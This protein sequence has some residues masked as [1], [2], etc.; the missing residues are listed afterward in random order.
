LI[1][2]FG[3]RE[4][5]LDKFYGIGGLYLVISDHPIHGARSLQYIGKT[6]SFSRRLDEHQWIQNE[7]RVEIYLA[8]LGDE[9]SRDD[10]EKLM[11]YAHSPSYNSKNISKPPNLT[12]N[13]RIWNYGRFWK[14]Y[15]E[16]SSLH[17]WYIPD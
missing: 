14:L 15:P 7:W 3:P 1:D 9:I 10:V 12:H 13:Y 5:Q 8:E 4:D 2:K 16:I 6:N 17:D 11:I